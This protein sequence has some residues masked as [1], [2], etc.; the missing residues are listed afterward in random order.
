MARLNREGREIWFERYWGGYI[1]CHWRGWAMIGAISIPAFVIGKLLPLVVARFF[2]PG[3]ATIVTAL[4]YAP[5]IWLAVLF[6]GRH[7][8]TRD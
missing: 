8:P 3:T 4:L 7:T 5:F 1:P 6:L 2:P